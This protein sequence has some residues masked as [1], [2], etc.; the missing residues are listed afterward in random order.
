MAL[1][2]LPDNHP[3]IELGNLLLQITALR[4]A[5]PT[6]SLSHWRRLVLAVTASIQPPRSFRYLAW[7][8][9]W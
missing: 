8:A 2:L 4:E 5:E 6:N 7:A 3:E 9:H 1:D